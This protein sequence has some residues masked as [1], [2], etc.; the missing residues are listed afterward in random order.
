M[1]RVV[2]V[3]GGWAGCGAAV[4]AAK[5]G[6]DEVV[7]FEKTDLLLGTGL[8]GGI[9][10][11]NGRFT[12]TEEM[13]ALGAG[14]PF[15]A[16]D[17]V[18][19]HHN[20]AFPGHKHAT[21]YD[22]T[23]IE[24]AMRQVLD[25]YGVKVKMVSRVT[26]VRVAEQ[27]ASPAQAGGFWTILG[28]K[29]PKPARY[30][31]ITAIEYYEKHGADF[32]TPH[33]M[34]ADVF[35]ETT[36]SVGPQS[37]CARYGNGCVMCIIRCPTFGGRV[38]IA[39]LCGVPEMI[40]GSAEDKLGAFSGS[41][42]LVKESLS[43]EIVHQLQTTGLAIIALPED[44]IEVGKLGKKACQQYATRDYAENIILLDTGHAKLMT[45]YYPLEKLRRVPGFENARFD[46]PYSGGIGNSV[47]YLAI[48]PRDNFLQVG[49]M[50]NLF[51][52]G[53]KAGP[54]VGHTEACVTGS[55]AGHNAVRYSLG[56]PLL[57][58]PASLAVGDAISHVG[59]MI[60]KGGLFK[61]YTFSGAGYFERMKELGLYTTD[62]AAI[63]QRVADAG[64]TNAFSQD[65][66]K[67][68][69]VRQMTAAAGA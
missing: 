16:A 2:V 30:K 12:A 1:T 34:E 58:L 53:E 25:Q 44:Q 54:L 42:K 37:E 50:I 22:V 18:A 55:L 56:L 64:L 8:V 3:G 7:L 5:A 6:A 11:N 21:L 68:P 31:R 36:G 62:V 47:R 46:D 9:M 49:G 48:S 24:P 63:G 43:P 39:A 35:I 57:E 60:T 4:A 27:A 28:K 15:L 61:K 69:V 29:V 26:D 40:G 52:G 33:W 10:R 38:S 23:K 66:R 17:A 19:R 20:M 65:L 67:S 14:D 59:E 41:C 45:S 51:C 13:I 32:G